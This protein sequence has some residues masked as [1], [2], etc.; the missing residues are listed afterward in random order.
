MRF[1]KS[2]QQLIIP[3]YGSFYVDYVGRKA[4]IKKLHTKGQDLDSAYQL[5]RDDFLRIE[6]FRAR[7]LCSVHGQEKEMIDNFHLD[8]LPR[9]IPVPSFRQS[10]LHFLAEGYRGLLNILAELRWFDRVNKT[11]AR[12]LFCKLE[13]ID[14][15]KEGKH[16]AQCADWFDLYA[17]SEEKTTAAARRMSALLTGLDRARSDHAPD[18]HAVPLKKT[19]WRFGSASDRLPDIRALHHLALQGDA[20]KLIQLAHPD[21]TFGSGVVQ[22]DQVI[23][24][25]I[26]NH[27][28]ATAVQ[29][30][31]R[32]PEYVQNMDK[33][34]LLFCMRVTLCARSAEDVSTGPEI[35]RREEELLE[36]FRR[37]LQLCS[38]ST[39]RSLNPDGSGAELLSFAVKHNLTR[40]CEMIL[41]LGGPVM[42]R[43]WVTELMKAAKGSNLPSPFEIMLYQRQPIFIDAI[44]CLGEDMHG[45][46][47]HDIRRIL[48]GFLT[49]AVRLQNDEAFRCLIDAGC[50]FSS[51]SAGERSSS[52]N[53]LH[54]AALQGRV[55][56]VNL[57]LAAIGERRETLD[58]TEPRRGLTALAIACMHGH[59][60]VVKALLLAGADASVND[61]FGWTAKEHAAGPASNIPAMAEPVA[62]TLKQGE[63]A[64]IVNLGSIQARLKEDTVV[65]NCCSSNPATAAKEDTSYT[66]T[67]SAPQESQVGRFKTSM[68]F[69]L[70]LIND[71]L[72]TN[73]CVF[74][75][76]E[77]ATLVLTFRITARSRH[78]P[79]QEKVVGIGSAVLEGT[80]LAAGC[81]REN[82]VRERT[83]AILD[84]DTMDV[85][86]L[87]QNIAKDKYLQ[88][89]ENTIQSFLAAAKLGAS[90]VELTRDLE[91][92]VYHD[93]S[94]SESGTDI[95]IHDLTLEQFRYA[96]KVQS[97]Q[98]NPASVIGSPHRPTSG[99]APRLRSRSVSR[100]EP[101][102]TQVQDRVKLT[103]DFRNKGLKPNTRG[104]F[105]HDSLVTLEELL[106]ELPEDL[107]LNIEF[108]H[109][110]IHET[111][112]AGVAPVVIEINKFIDVA[113]D[114]IRQSAGANR[115][116]V[117]SSFTPSN[118]GK[119]PPSDLDKRA[120]SVQAAVHFARWWGL[121]GI[122]FASEPFLLCPRLVRFVRN[123]GLMCG[124]YGPQ[125]NEPDNVKLQADAGLDLLVTDRV[126]LIAKALTEHGAGSE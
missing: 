89:G 20:E 104:E 123:A 108:K 4:L 97:P 9:S 68:T 105:I 22:L 98:G 14:T 5:L 30:L 110:R 36:V 121:A 15:Q 47:D 46:A 52:G 28:E 99:S 73:P 8:E 125:N 112:A 117:L 50:K 33:D 115:P 58:A 37:M 122:V 44:K 45:N 86:G 93:F 81:P 95:P 118:A 19:P 94:F 26:L 69:N 71:D 119:P 100:D 78:G 114:K 77:D 21:S 65:V 41:Y 17:E 34:C 120:A 79:S 107:G 2:F 40:Y 11:A 70:P 92:V 57:L 49:A 3:E 60:G 90:F 29:I 12:R 102:A 13:R 111:I 1:G 67:V 27:L 10:E 32:S 43:D 66:L 48:D 109:P 113:L 88:I 51:I 82:L 84:C 55:D 23:K 96:S 59:E 54:I 80:K 74:L 103:V 56:Y 72:D 75:L 39:R 83:A 91:A 42:N 38:S 18:P 126:G 61:Q 124:T 25:L 31:E 63:Q 62:P 24:Y 106:S 53:A 87:G 6:E 7:F 116:L 76:R 16:G 64:I 35:S 85:V 101:G